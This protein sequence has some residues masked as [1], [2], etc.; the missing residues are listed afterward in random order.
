MANKNKNTVK[1]A[2]YK[3]NRGKKSNFSDAKDN[4][5]A[6]QTANKPKSNDNR[7][8]G[9]NPALLL[10]ST[11]V[12]FT[13]PIGRDF[14]LK[15]A[16]GFSYVKSDTG[17]SLPGIVVANV[18]PTCG[19]STNANSAVNTAARQIATTL[20]NNSGRTHTYDATDIMMYTLAMDDI[21]SMFINGQRALGMINN[22]DGLNKYACESMIQAA[23]FQY[24]DLISHSAQ[25]RYNM[26]VIAAKLASFP[27]PSEYALL[28]KHAWV[29]ANVF[30]DS[31]LTKSQF[32]LY[33]PAGYYLLDETLSDKGWVL[34]FNSLTSVY[35]N[36]GFTVDEYIDLL[37]LMIDRVYNSESLDIIRADL[38]HNLSGSELYTISGIPDGFKVDYVYNE[39]VLM[40]F[41]NM[42]MYGVINVKD[43]ATGKIGSMDIYNEVASDTDYN[44]PGVIYCNYRATANGDQR[45]RHEIMATNDTLLDMPIEH[46][47]GPDIMEYTRLTCVLG[48]KEHSTKFDTDYYPIYFDTICPMYLSVYYL[49]GGELYVRKINPSKLW[50]FKNSTVTWAD[51][52]EYITQD[53]ICSQ[54]AWAPIFERQAISSTGTYEQLPLIG[55]V[56]N[57]TYIGND[58]IQRMHETAI[59]SQFSVPVGKHI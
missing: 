36:G 58:A 31:D 3:S 15:D 53:S 30:R 59:L 37:N 47:D 28:E 11:K 18:M 34:Q 46:P 20:W 45:V 43:K 41:H 13:T 42:K 48:P 38:L 35:D 56:T 33:R 25:F 17:R 24:Q 27:V 26:N 4:F 9:Y 7:W 19:T 8:Y 5:S 40:Q 1:S 32:Y 57:Y 2:G 49:N 44:K 22:F 10:D 52:I 21:Y 6:A 23:G 14:P 16:P 12:N 29:F 50:A 39:T 51:F 55:D 54:F